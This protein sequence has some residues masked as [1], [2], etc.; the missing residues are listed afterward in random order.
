MNY[1]SNSSS[2]SYVLYI[3]KDI[4]NQFE[5][6]FEEF[7]H[8]IKNKFKQ[9]ENEDFPLIYKTYT[10]EEIVKK[11]IIT[12]EGVKNPSD[13]LIEFFKEKLKKTENEKIWLKDFVEV[14]YEIDTE[15]YDTIGFQNMCESFITNYNYNYNFKK[16]ESNTI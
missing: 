11:Y 12:K 4:L 2:S 15:S 1:V 3:K 9:Y 14:K 7:I 5:N 8:F 16:N 13:D 10:E 6:D